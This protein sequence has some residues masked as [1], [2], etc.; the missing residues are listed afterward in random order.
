M[1]WQAAQLKSSLRA[2][3]GNEEE[4]DQFNL[5]FSGSMPRC[6][7]EDQNPPKEEAPSIVEKDP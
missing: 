4:V 3:H 2:E 5:S 7:I 1:V 6:Y